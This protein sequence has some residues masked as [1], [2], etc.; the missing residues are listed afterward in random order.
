MPNA[1]RRTVLA[2]STTIVTV[3][4]PAF[5]ETLVGLTST[6]QLLTFDSAAPTN[7]STPTW[8]TG[9]GINESIIGIDRRPVS[10]VLYG[11]GSQN[12]LYTLDAASGA[13]T[14]VAS[15]VADP[16]DASSPFAG[17]A[18]TAFGIDF[19]PVPD[20]G[21]TLPSLRIVSNSGQNLRVNVNGAS[22]GLVTTDTPLGVTP[23]GTAS[24]VAAAY[25]NNDRN[26]ATGTSLFDIDASA[27]L[28]YQQINPNGG[29]LSAIGPLGV[30]A[31]GVSGFDISGSGLAFA[32]LLDSD[33]AKSSLYTINL[34]TG[35][36]TLTGAFGIGGSTAIAPPLL[37]LAAAPVPEPGTYALMALGLLGVGFAIRRGRNAS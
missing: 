14:L 28:L 29:V 1:F 25:A 35:V 20:L 3:A 32:A 21:M 22:A 30:D 26:P 2:L 9:L 12:N 18:G 6:N 5:A 13:A 7:A 27:D 11:L 34:A 16:T 37:D 36:A 24:I 10:G 15:L 33:T 31:S 8:I 19:N 17:L 23:S 4:A